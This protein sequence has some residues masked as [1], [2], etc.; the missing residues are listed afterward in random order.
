MKQNAW[1]AFLLGCSCLITQPLCAAERIQLTLGGNLLSLLNLG[2][3][4]GDAGLGLSRHTSLHLKGI[5][6]PFSWTWNGQPRQN[7][8][9]TLGIQGRYW[10]WYQFSGWYVGAKLQHSLYNRTGWFQPDAQ[11]GWRTGLGA[12]VGYCLL[13]KKHLNLEFSAGIWTGYDRHKTYESA[14]CGRLLQERQGLFFGIDRISIALQYL[15]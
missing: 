10:P 6:N 14:C 1:V 12:E 3:L 7:K 9:L 13:L 8:Q 5:Y 2:T 4:E 11:E 15:F